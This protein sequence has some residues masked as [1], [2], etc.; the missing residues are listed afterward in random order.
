M[1]TIALP[2]DD[3]ARF[4]R[5]CIVEEL[6]GADAARPSGV[7]ARERH[8][9]FVTL[10]W[11]SGRL[12]GCIGKIDPRGAVVDEVAEHAIA[13]ATRDPRGARL[14][15][16]DT[17]DLDVELSILSPTEP[18]AAASERE[19]LARIEPL[20]HGVVFEHGFRRATFLPAVWE[21]LRDGRAFM[22]ALKEKA[23]YPAAF[24]DDDV[25]IYVYTVNKHVDRA[26][27]PS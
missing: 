18:V 27:R 13:A 23:G 22:G 14:S 19:A 21:S 9:T 3:L 20:V 15:L 7:W 25:R 5:A 4:A 2:G 8:G 24:W 26:R 10:R 17:E 12:Q 1:T 11:S 16:G 6:G